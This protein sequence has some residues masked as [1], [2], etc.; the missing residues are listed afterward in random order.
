[1]IE[2]SKLRVSCW[3]FSRFQKE[4]STGHGQYFQW[5]VVLQNLKTCRIL[6]AFK[7]AAATIAAAA[8]AHTS[9]PETWLMSVL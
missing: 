3:F 6:A 2:P 4:K 1:M 7:V 5:C 8:A 9:E